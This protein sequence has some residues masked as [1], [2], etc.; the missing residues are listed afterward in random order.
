MTAPLGGFRPGFEPV[1]VE[2]LRFRSVDP[3]DDPSAHRRWQESGAA[4]IT[5]AGVQTPVGLVS[6]VAALAEWLDARGADLDARTQHRG[7]GL[8][9]ERVQILGLGRSGRT[10]CGGAG[11]F[12]KAQDGWLVV[13]LA[14]ESD[15]ELVPAWLDCAVSGDVWA[16]SRPSL[17]ARRP[18]SCGIERVSWALHAV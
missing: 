16:R 18:E 5:A 7:L 4:A 8:L 1:E 11:R 15:L 12:V 17:H 9:V 2:A 6:G 14:R 13:T 3:V 10:S